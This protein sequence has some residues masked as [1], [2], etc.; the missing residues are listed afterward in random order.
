MGVR[1][2]GP[3]SLTEASGHRRSFPTP[4]QG[5]PMCS[6]LATYSSSGCECRGHDPSKKAW[7]Q[8]LRCSDGVQKPRA[9]AEHS[10]D[11]LEAGAASCSVKPA[12]VV[13][14]RVVDG[15]GQVGALGL[16]QARQRQAAIARHVHM[17]P[18]N[19]RHASG[20]FMSDSRQAGSARQ[21]GGTSA[22]SSA[23]GRAS[24]HQGLTSGSCCRTVPASCRCT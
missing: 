21:A 20:D 10:L 18:K 3:C 9:L 23:S 5:E 19:K 16:G 22:A 24:M 2:W 11:C 8:A 12:S 7:R 4:H 14:H 17:P 1:G 13:A 6:Q 15:L